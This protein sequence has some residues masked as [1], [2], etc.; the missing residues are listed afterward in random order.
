M[1]ARLQK[2]TGVYPMTLAGLGVNVGYADLRYPNGF[3]VR[4][5]EQIAKAPALKTQGPKTLPKSP[6]I[7]NP[8]TKHLETKTPEARTLAPR[9]GA[10]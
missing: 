2:F 10:A 9:T 4:K 1:E 7:K 5:P 8:E 6:E 3:A